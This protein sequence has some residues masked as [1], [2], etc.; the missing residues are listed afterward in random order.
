MILRHCHWLLPAVFVCSATHLHAAPDPLFVADKAP[1]RSIRAQ[2]D[3]TPEISC[4]FSAPPVRLA[5]SEAVERA[6]CQNPAT[7]AAW[8]E[9]RA[10]AALLGVAR[11]A[12]L[13]N[14]GASASYL[15]QRSSSR[16]EGRYAVL[17]AEIRPRTRSG[18]LKMSWTLLDSGLR[19]ANTDQAQALLDAANAT[20]DLSIQRT[21]LETAQTYF[22]AQTAAAML[23]ATRAAEASAS[24]SHEATE[25]KYAAGVGA[26]TDKLQAAVAL[27][28][29]RLKRV[30]AEGELKN[31]LG[32]LSTAIGLSPDTPLNLPEQEAS[33][34]DP[35]AA[36]V[37]SLLADARE[38][39]PALVA[40]RAELEAAEARVRA[41]RAEGRP[42][43]A[44][45]AEVSERR[46][47]K[48]IPISGYPPT[49]ASFR[50]SV[51]GMQLSVPL[52]EGFGRIYK[53]S[54]ADSQV[55]LKQAE[56]KRIEQQVALEVWQ[57]Y[58]SLATRREHIEAAGTLLASARRSFEV[59]EGRFRA[60]VGSILELISA[61]SALASAEQQRIEAHAKW[62]GA[63][64]KLA[65]SV[66]RLGLWAIR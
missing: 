51:I 27:S 38:H 48:H 1:A 24:K 42:T 5:L 64:L 41:T 60:G 32:A 61:Q 2:A 12:Y 20:H 58:Q 55:D 10:R 63:R 37:S 19:G 14:V 9:A 52:F 54:A 11:S 4:E 6:L 45:S 39:H 44:L 50:D 57:S 18:N 28:D 43:L 33:L 65:A 53:V 17:D 40:A 36:D 34:P 62:L 31:A 7:R 16:Y 22:N 3:T 29:A 21:L 13:P 23:R 15:A 56:L 49:G 8:A 35:Q 47:D 66:G 26:L 59:A 25:A 46:Q 30:T